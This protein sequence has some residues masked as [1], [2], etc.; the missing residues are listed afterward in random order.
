MQRLQIV[1]SW[2]AGGSGHEQV[3]DVAGAPDNG[4]DVDLA[5]CTPRGI[6]FDNLCTVWRDPDFDPTQPAA[7]YARVLENPSC[8]WNTYV[9]N[10]SRR[11]LRRPATYPGSLAA[12][13]DPEIPKTIQERAW[14]S[15]IWYEPTRP[16]V[17]AP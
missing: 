1:K 2:V 11:R 9:C 10:R 3:F 17:T 5:T 4:A 15:P 13:C 8:R 12:C 7:Y 6:G 16:V 14:T